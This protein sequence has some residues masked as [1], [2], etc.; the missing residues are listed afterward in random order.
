MRCMVA[1]D[2]FIIWFACASVIAFT[3]SNKQDKAKK[4]CEV[5]NCE[6]TAVYRSIPFWSKI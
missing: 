5:E 6:E 1:I 3:T 2:L 4:A